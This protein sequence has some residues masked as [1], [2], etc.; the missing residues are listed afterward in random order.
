MAVFRHPFIAI[1]ILSL[2][3][4]PL[5]SL[6]APTIIPTP[7]PTATSIPYPSVDHHNDGQNPNWGCPFQGNSDLYG[8]G[9]R[10]GVYLQLFSTLLANGFLSNNI[11]EDARNTNA[12][13][14]IAVFAGMASATIN[15]NMNGVEIFL[16]TTLLMCFLFSDFT[17]SHISYVVLWNGAPLK[18]RMFECYRSTEKILEEMRRAD[19]AEKER[20]GSQEKKRHFAAISRSVIGT[21]I[22]LFTAWFWLSGRHTL[23]KNG[24]ENP[25]CI[26]TIFLETQIELEGNQPMLYVVGSVLYAI[27]E[28]MFMMWWVAILAPGTMRLLYDIVSITTVS[29]CTGR[30]K[31]VRRI[32]AKIAHWYLG[33]ARLDPR[34]LKMFDRLK[35][36][37]KRQAQMTRFRFLGSW[38]GLPL[39]YGVII[40]SSISIELTIAWNEI[41]GVYIL[42]STGQLIP[43]VVG[44]LGLVRNLHLIAMK[45][46]ETAARR[47]EEK[48]RDIKIAWETGTYV[49]GIGNDKELKL[50]AFRPGRRWSIDS[51]NLQAQFEKSESNLLRR[52]SGL[53]QSIRSL[54]WKTQ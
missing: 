50:E 2:S 13:I 30:V 19:L 11:I 38:F 4:A 48:E 37:K 12:I 18:R 39:G 15:G 47:A 23:L 54:S 36:S 25:T 40:W 22:G 29:L 5:G 35:M 49:Y 3:I 8:L 6:A 14:M 1:L 45:M 21:A 33:F 44:V 31:E 43:F 42:G 51:G 28:V 10:L 46:S 7:T 9:I 20:E 32:R 24:I 53:A 52:D 41:S 27:W 26:P 16:M 17:P 34:T